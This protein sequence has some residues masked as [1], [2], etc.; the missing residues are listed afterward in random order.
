L[1]C[2]EV[3]GFSLYYGSLW[4]NSVTLEQ[5]KDGKRNNLEFYHQRITQVWVVE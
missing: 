2:E 4:N 1:V 3:L 5:S